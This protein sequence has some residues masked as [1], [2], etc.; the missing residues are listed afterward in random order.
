[1]KKKILISYPL[2]PKRLEKLNGKYEVHCV[3]DMQDR[4]AEVIARIQDYHGLLAMNLKVDEAMLGRSDRL[5]IISNYGVGY[6]NID[7][8]VA[9]KKGIAVAN[10]PDSTSMAT[11][12]YT[13]GLILALL[14][15]IA[16][17]D[18]QIRTSKLKDWDQSGHHGNSLSGKL[19]GILGMGR[20]GKEV[21]RLATAFGMQIIYHSPRRLSSEIEE[22]DRYQ[23]VNLE[24]LIERAD[25]L[26]IHAPLNS[27]T[28]HLVSEDLIR[29]MQSHA[30]IINT[31]RGNLIDQDAL[32][33][34]LKNHQISGAALDVFAD[35]PEIPEALLELDH[36]VLSPH[37]GTGTREARSA[38]FDE[39]FNNMVAFFEGKVLSGR[40]I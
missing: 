26:T 3:V 17:N 20:I 35:E 40:V 22:F 33:D 24:E 37:N 6:D 10:T 30:W 29:R 13:M 1:M 36:V 19:L 27:T 9:R 32:V 34:A 11:A 2:K 14:R 23:F 31:S 16:L 28:H 4:Y 7:I 5:E 15:K 12:E 39:A 18:R 8:N 25:I 21:A 38:M